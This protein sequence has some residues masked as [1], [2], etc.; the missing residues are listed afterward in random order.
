MNWTYKQATGWIHDK[1]GLVRGQGFAGRDPH[2][3]NPASESLKGLG[4][5]PRGLYS[6][7]FIGNTDTHG[8]FVIG[9]EPLDESVMFGR[10]GFLIHGDSMHAPGTGSHGCICAPLV[11]RQEIIADVLLGVKLLKVE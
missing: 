1:H 6:M 10:S 8:P 3:N 9:L 5:L 7:R 2:K 11:V 4:P